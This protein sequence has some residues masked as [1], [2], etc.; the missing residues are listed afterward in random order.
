MSA[1]IKILIRDYENAVGK[2]IL[3][4]IAEL[5]FSLGIRKTI[6]V[7]KGSKSSFIIDHDLHNLETYSA[8]PTFAGEQL[9]TI[10][11]ALIKLK[12]LEVEFVSKYEN[13]PVLKITPKGRDF[14]GGKYE[15][16]V[17]FTKSLLSIRGIGEKFVKNYGDEFI[18][19]VK[20]HMGG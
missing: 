11:G 19:L 1:D 2:I 13:M 7:L 20:S 5:P 4:C 15:T 9:R 12:L 18:E 16:N 3:Y 10:I 14:I 6:S 8:F 17:S